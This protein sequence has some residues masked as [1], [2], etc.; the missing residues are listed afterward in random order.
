MP[1]LNAA[2]AMLALL[3][4]TLGVPHVPCVTVNVLV[5]DGYVIVPLV[6]LILPLQVALDTLYVNWCFELL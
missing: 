1:L 3:V 6:G 5:V 2:V 4:A